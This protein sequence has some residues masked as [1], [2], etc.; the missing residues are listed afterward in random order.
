M[1]PNENY[2]GTISLKNIVEGFSAEYAISMHSCAQ[3]TG[4]AGI[5]TR[6]LL[7]F[8][9]EV[10]GLRRIYLNVRADNP[11]AIRFYEKMHFI[12]EGTARQALRT[13]DGYVDLIWFAILESD[14]KKIERQ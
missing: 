7:R 1:D 9:F 12:Y 3:G 2:L 8:A 5:G 11:R 13:K 10:L 14:W 6:D 4:V